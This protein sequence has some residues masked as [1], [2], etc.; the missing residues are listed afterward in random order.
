MPLIFKKDDKFED[1]GSIEDFFSSYGDCSVS[2]D[3]I[4]EPNIRLTIVSEQFCSNP[5]SSIIRQ[6]GGF[7]E[8][9]GKYRILRITKEDGS[10]YI[11][12]SQSIDID[13][14]QPSSEIERLEKTLKGNI[15]HFI[16]IENLKN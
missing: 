2:I 7:P 16:K 3:N 8:G 12:L 9:M 6:N 14:S 4:D 11:R 1:L 13:A 5:L 15:R 10:S